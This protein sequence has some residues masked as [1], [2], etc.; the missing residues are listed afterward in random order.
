MPNFTLSSPFYN[1]P[2][3][4]RDVRCYWSIIGDTGK[5]IQVKW[6]DVDLINQV[7]YLRD[8]E[9]SSLSRDI[10]T[11]FHGNVGVDI[12][13]V[14]STRGGFIL[15]YRASETVEGKGFKVDVSLRGK[16]VNK[17]LIW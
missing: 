13:P 15:E 12:S 16:R 6:I 14:V 9:T 8:L 7:V 10:I 2:I 5:Q 4:T 11:N 17:H 3:A 1:Q